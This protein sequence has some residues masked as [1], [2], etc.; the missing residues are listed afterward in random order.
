MS[1]KIPAELRAI[2]DRAHDLFMK[3]EVLLS[4]TVIE[5]ELIEAAK[6]TNNHL[7]HQ[8]ALLVLAR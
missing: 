2:R 8:Y 1:S 5:K 4:F 3:G 6:S 7:Y